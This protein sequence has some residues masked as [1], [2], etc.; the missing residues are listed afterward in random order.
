M[1]RK[2]NEGK[3]CGINLLDAFEKQISQKQRSGNLRT[4]DNYRSTVNK[5][6]VYQSGKPEELT[7]G[8]VTGEWV[9]GFVDWL[10]K[11]HPNKPQTADFYFR[12]MRAM[13]HGA[14]KKHKFKV[15]EP[16]FKDMA[17]SGRPSAKRALNKDE[18]NKLFSPA[19][20][21]Q[22][23]E[24]FRQ[25]LDVLHFMLFMRGMVFQDLYSLTWDMVDSD[26][27][28]HYLRSKTQVPIDMEL[29]PE[30][31]QIIERYREEG[32]I[33]VFPFLH[34]SKRKGGKQELSEQS[35]LRRVNRHA[36]EIGKQ[37]GLPIALSTYVMR[38]TFAT[39]MI[40]ASKPLELVSQCLGHASI[41]TTELY[42]SRISINKVD[43]EVN[44]MFDQMLR[45]ATTSIGKK[46]KRNRQSGITKTEKEHSSLPVI[47]ESGLPAA[48]QTEIVVGIKKY[49]F[50]HKKETLIP[51]ILFLDLIS[52][53][54]IHI[55]SN[56]AN[57]YHTFF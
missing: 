48:E 32:S 57:F 27:H 47:V 28:I 12:N 1:K 39:L 23:K 50:L 46:K 3:G 2:L 24:C 41:R 31:H 56:I 7:L 25:S 53:A 30:A 29:S 21:E 43:K 9:S 19:L 51:E 33:Y 14:C 38:H 49:P 11:M 44:D 8:T 15:E 5:L 17:F 10:K 52:A 22:L 55:L 16:P 42:I 40:E 4:A 35:A 6:Q 37:A 26:N 34:R 13:F 45:P 54:K 36:A 20:Y 18:I